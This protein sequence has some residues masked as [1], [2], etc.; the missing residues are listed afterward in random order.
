VERVGVAELVD[1]EEAAARLARVR[2]KGAAAA[3]VLRAVPRQEEPAAIAHPKSGLVE[4]A[5]NVATLYTPCHGAE[6]MYPR[7][8]AAGAW[9]KAIC[10]VCGAA[11]VVEVQADEHAESG[12]RACWADTDSGEEVG[13]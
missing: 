3:G 1:R 11:R 5:G 6:Q 4:V 9:L 12:L 2:P 10:G 7:Q 8:D 13:R